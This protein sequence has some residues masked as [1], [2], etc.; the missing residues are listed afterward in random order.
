M[1]KGWKQEREDPCDY[2]ENVYKQLDL[3]I[4]DRDIEKKTDSGHLKMESSK[5]SYGSEAQGERRQREKG[6]SKY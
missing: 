3:K 5:F 6:G 4:H 1:K 2:L